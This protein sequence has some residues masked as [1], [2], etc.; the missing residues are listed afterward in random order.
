MSMLLYTTHRRKNQF[1]IKFY[2]HT[3]RKTDFVIDIDSAKFRKTKLT[4]ACGHLNVVKCKEKA[5]KNK[6]KHF[7]MLVLCGK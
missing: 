2:L 1:V 5:K 7:K 3:K 6:L 4:M